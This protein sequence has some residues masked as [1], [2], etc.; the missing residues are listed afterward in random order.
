VGDE[1]VEALVRPGNGSRLEPVRWVARMVM[2]NLWGIVNTIILK[3]NDGHAESVN[4]RIRMPRIR[5]RGYRCRERSGA[6]STSTSA[7]SISI[8]RAQGEGCQAGQTISSPS[9][10]PDTAP[11][12]GIGK[13]CQEKIYVWRIFFPL[14]FKGLFNSRRGNKRM[15]HA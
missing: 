10:A 7:V 14:L 8:R 1:G 2:K 3:G 9:R 13:W 15:L 11:Y 12:M 6:Q 5:S 4:S